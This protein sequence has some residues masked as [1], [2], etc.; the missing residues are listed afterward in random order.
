[1]P[2]KNKVYTA[3]ITG[4][5]SE[6]SGVCRIE[7]MAVFVPETAVGDVA[8]I[9][10]VKVLSSYAFGIVDRLVTPSPDRCERPCG[11]YKKC[12]GCVYRHIS[13][14]AEC[15]AKE[16]VVRDAFERIGGLSPQFDSFLAAEVTDRYRNKAQYPLAVADGRAVCGFFAPRSHRVVPIEDCPLQPRVFSN[17]AAAVLAYIN[18]RGISVYDEKTGSGI[19]RHIYLRR[20]EH[21][22]EVMI[23]LVAR[24]DVSRQLMPLCRELAESF[25]DVKS[26]VLNINPARTNVILG[27]RCITLWGRNTITDVMCGN[28]VEIS[29]LSFYQVNTVQA[30]RLYAK[31]LE[32]AAPTGSEVIADLYCGAGT[33]GLSMAHRAARIVGVEIVPEAVEN[34]RG[35]AERNGIANAEFFCGDAGEVFGQLRAKG[36]KPD[37]IVVDP[38]RKGCSEET[39]GH[40][41]AAAP[42][43][44]VMIS[45]NPSTAARDTKFLC[46]HGYAAERVCGADLF[47]ATRHVECVVLMTKY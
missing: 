22:G 47:P 19:M 8:E 15:R 9:K 13:Y 26:V 38:P 5:T 39:L 12:G 3:E 46:G 25:P 21:S 11:V 33:I 31:A 4:L 23:C 6:G 16:A 35:N 24:K 27:E 2:E 34:A 41:V 40:I 36:C 7:E 29:P 42:E 17:I 10:I 30:E 44:V 28:E 37:I 20:G 43:K 1:M 18:A 45:C 32:Y 14:D